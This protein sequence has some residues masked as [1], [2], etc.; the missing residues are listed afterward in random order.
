MRA[1]RQ[2]TQMLADGP[3][4]VG[5]IPADHDKIQATISAEIWASRR[6]QANAMLRRELT[7]RLAASA[8]SDHGDPGG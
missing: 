1:D 2:I 7:R 6:D 3:S 4:V 5:V 8:E